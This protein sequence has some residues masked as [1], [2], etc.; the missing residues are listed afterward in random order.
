MRSELL[1]KDQVQQQHY[2]YQRQKEQLEAEYAM[3]LE[4]IQDNMNMLDKK[5]FDLTQFNIFSKQEKETMK[6][7]LFR[8]E[9][10]FQ[11]CV[12]ANDKLDKEIEEVLGK[13]VNMNDLQLLNK[14]DLETLNQIKTDKSQRLNEIAEN[15]AAHKIQAV[16]KGKM[17]RR[18][19]EELRKNK[20]S[21]DCKNKDCAHQEMHS[22]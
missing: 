6:N 2:A 11:S 10:R 4:Q 14:L 8:E 15:L 5:H 17:A 21:K 7:Q 12:E 16:H 9:V 3:R 13:A 18:D 19:V 20:H 22:E 1:Q